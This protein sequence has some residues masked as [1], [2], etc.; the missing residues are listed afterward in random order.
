L[1]LFMNAGRGHD[2]STKER[3]A[4]NKFAAPG[5]PDK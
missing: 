4:P 1:D 2:P 3:S 5:N